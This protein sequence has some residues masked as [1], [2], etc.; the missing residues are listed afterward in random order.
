MKNGAE[1]KLFER[2]LEFW[3]LKSLKITFKNGI[4]KKYLKVGVLKIKF[5]KIGI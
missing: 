5:K 3:K 4:K 1:L 2:K